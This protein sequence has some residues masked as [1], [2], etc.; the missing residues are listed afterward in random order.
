MT[1][2]VTTIRPGT[3]STHTVPVE[4]LGQNI[5][6]AGGT[7]E[8]L[9]ADRLRNPKFLG[10]ADPQ[11]GIAPQ[12]RSFPD[13]MHWN[14][15]CELTPGLALSGETSQMLC[16]YSS[17][18]GKGLVQPDV[19][20]RAD[21]TLEV[22]LWALA[23]SGQTT[24][25]IGIRPRIAKLPPY[26]AVE[27]KIDK[28]FWENYRVTL[29]SPQDDDTAEFYI[30]MRSLSLVWFDQVHLRPQ[31]EFLRREVLEEFHRVRPPVLRYPGGCECT[32]FRWRYSVGP[33]HLRP[34]THD[35]VFKTHINYDYGTDEF[36]RMCHELGATPHIS[37]AIGNG[38]PE[39]AADW[40]QY[41]H[42]W[43]RQR[44][45]EPPLMYWHLGNE[46]NGA[47]ELGHM[48]GAM[49]AEVLRRFVPGI[50]KGYP[51]NRI[52]A[53]GS[54]H[55]YI[56]EQR[57]WRETILNEAAGYFDVLALQS[58]GYAD[59]TA[60]ALGATVD[61]ERLLHSICSNLQE[62]LLPAVRETIE[63]GQSVQ[64]AKAV[65][66]TEWNLWT[67][68]RQYHESGRYEEPA[69]GAHL[70]FVALFQ[71]GLFAMGPGLELVNYYALFNPMGMIQARGREVRVTPIAELFRLWRD[72]LPAKYLP[73]AM[74]G[75]GV[76]SAVC[77]ASE[78][79][80]Y[81]FVV[82]TDPHAEQSVSLQELGNPVELR[83]INATS[84]DDI[85][86]VQPSQVLDGNAEIVLPP[87]SVSRIELS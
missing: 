15:R 60:T 7:A 72:A 64:P 4:L 75:N 6:V 49:Y 45:I 18:M 82:N 61:P 84:A 34:H 25:E 78:Q 5:E 16:L 80:R 37:V 69:D 38:T 68:L 81:L 74:D 55:S 46:H 48:D 36:L 33:V 71:H 32:S 35:P 41:C 57:P 22:D 56:G 21:E 47:W 54:A 87:L 29:R 77:L 12:W 3:G 17:V 63:A 1:Q 67:H 70:L 73:I 62:K 86:V 76:L 50:R 51:N 19:W 13:V 23:Q 44:G 30:K 8:G 20:L 66:I 65:A 24:V 27:L 52:I 43:F 40:A 14:W 28:P 39:D 2:V 11:T 42:D 26:D 10:P 59:P 53:I 58:Y 83:T 79:H 85:A 9:L 31:G